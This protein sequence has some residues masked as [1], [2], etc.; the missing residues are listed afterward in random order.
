M[1]YNMCAHRL[2]D[3]YLSHPTRYHYTDMSLL[4]TKKNRLLTTISRH[5]FLCNLMWQYANA[6]HV[7]TDRNGT[8]VIRSAPM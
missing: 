4:F 3:N 6:Y 5:N 1:M 7:R 2:K 8:L